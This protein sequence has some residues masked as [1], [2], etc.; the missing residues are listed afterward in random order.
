M[1]QIFAL[2][3]ALS[4][5]LLLSGCEALLS[6]N[7]FST[8]DTPKTPSAKSFNDMKDDELLST[9][10]VLVETDTFF[11]EIAADEEVRTSVVEGLSAIYD[12]GSEAD[13]AEKQ[14]ASLLVAEIEL[15]TTGAGEVVDDFVNVLTEY[16]EQPPESNGAEETVEAIVT[17]VFA[18]V[19]EENFDETLN[20]L[21]AAAEAYTY[22][23]ESLDDAGDVTAP[24]G[25]N[26]G[27]VAQNAVVA[28]LVSEMIDTDGDD[29]GLLSPEEFKAVVV[30]DE[31]FP[32][33]FV[34]EN[35]PIEENEA[36]V[37]I[38]SA[39]G[40]EDLFTA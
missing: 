34:L 18:D 40:M 4:M 11:E 31:P 9:V 2:F 27:A 38:L 3:F 17:K 13:I 36:L 33:D 35:N 25:T 7:L 32:E 28:I 39:S 14:K 6:F 10:A 1:K 21:L 26:S 20:A 37:N 12:D 24:E 22:Y 5:F 8:L 30:D 29:P 23:G 15:N 19:T 16:I